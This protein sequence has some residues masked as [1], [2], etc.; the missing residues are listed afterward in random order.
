MA[1]VLCNNGESLALK[2]LLNHT[3]QSENLVLKLY[4]NDI[5]PGETDTA[6]TYTEAT[7]YGYASK[8]LTGASWTVTPG[9]PTEAS[10]AQQTWTFTGALGNVYG[11]FIIRA[12]TADLVWAERFTNG[13][14]NVQNN[15]DEIKITPKITID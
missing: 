9:A 6:G 13:P 1:L 3:A 4:T 14:Y 10:Y 12:T 2:A 5:T 8:S 7:G 11:Y 15:G